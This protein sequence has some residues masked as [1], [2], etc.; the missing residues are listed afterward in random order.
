MMF[1]HRR[2]QANIHI[3]YRLIADKDAFS[4]LPLFSM[5][6]DIYAGLAICGCSLCSSH[7]DMFITNK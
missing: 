1:I 3:T 5:L 6:W 4:Y 2:V 7:I